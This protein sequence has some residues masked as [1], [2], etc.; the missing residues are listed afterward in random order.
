MLI[1][2]ERRDT[3]TINL[4]VCVEADWR[5]LDLA[6]NDGTKLSLTVRDISR[7]QA[8]LERSQV[9]GSGNLAIK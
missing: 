1:E 4:E 2:E 6:Y 3:S 5:K 9:A 8:A 7:R